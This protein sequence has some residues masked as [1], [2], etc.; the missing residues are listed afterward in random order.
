MRYDLEG[1]DDVIQVMPVFK[2]DFD[3]DDG[4]YQL[5]EDEDVGSGSNDDCH[6]NSGTELEHDVEA[7]YSSCNSVN[8]RVESS[9]GREP[10]KDFRTFMVQGYVLKDLEIKLQ[11]LSQNHSLN[12]PGSHS[13]SSCFRNS[14]GK[15][16]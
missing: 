11:R 8:Q 13:E 15:Y 4:G 12:V 7:S 9:R 3:S 2:E 10:L 16:Q 14:A 6:D 5:L 1:G